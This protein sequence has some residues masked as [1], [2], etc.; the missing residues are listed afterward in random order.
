MIMRLMRQSELAGKI[1]LLKLLVSRMEKKK[2]P[3]RTDGYYLQILTSSLSPF[4]SS[5]SHL[6]PFA[7]RLTRAA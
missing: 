5:F 1:K 7:E 2:D 3:M 4:S 6:F